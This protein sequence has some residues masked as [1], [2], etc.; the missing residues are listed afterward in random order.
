MSELAQ[1]QKKLDAF[2]TQL[3]RERT[4]VMGEPQILCPTGEA[5]VKFMSCGVIGEGDGYERAPTARVAL[6][7]WF[8]SFAYYVAVTP[9]VVYWLRRP[10]LEG[11]N[12]IGFNVYSRLCISDKRIDGAKMIAGYDSMVA[13]GD[14]AREEADRR[15]AL[16]RPFFAEEVV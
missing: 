1:L 11:A 7:K 8:G 15:I 12:D 3:E 6:L 13:V 14:M 10:E 4:C 9:G 16:Y 5:Y 2:V